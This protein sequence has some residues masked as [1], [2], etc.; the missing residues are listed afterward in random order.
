MRNY[1]TKIKYHIIFPIFILFHQSFHGGLMFRRFIIFGLF[2]ICFSFN[3]KSEFFKAEFQLGATGAGLIN[4]DEYSLH[5]FFAGYDSD[6]DGELNTDLGEEPASWYFFKLN[7]PN[8]FETEHILDFD[9]FI[10]FPFR[11]ARKGNLLYVPLEN[12]I[13]IC[14]LESKTILD[15]NFLEISAS[16]LS[17]FDNFLFISVRY[18]Y[19]YDYMIDDNFV[20][21]Y[22][23]QTK[24][25]LDTLEAYDFVQQTL[26]VMWGNNFYLFVLNE[27][28]FG[29]DDSKLQIFK[30]E[31]MRLNEIQ[32]IDIGSGG[33]YLAQ[34]EN[35]IAIVSSGSNKIHFFDLNTF[36]IYKSFDIPGEPWNGP[37]EI[38]FTGNDNI[39]KEAF[40]EFIVSTYDNKI[41]SHKNQEITLLDEFDYKI[42]S[43]AFLGPNLCA[44]SSFDADYNSAKSLYILFNPF[45]SI[46][47]NSSFDLKIY[48]NP[49]SGILQISNDENNIIKVIELYDSKGLFIEKIQNDINAKNI[50]INLNKFQLS[51][52]L[53]ILKIIS[54]NQIVNQPFILIK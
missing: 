37:R 4:T 20:I 30:Y 25:F 11:P 53:Y 34:Y 41:Y 22:E 15:N 16:A 21:V 12:K 48:P 28:N 2:L 18:D 8:N 32:V 24:R 47:K 31:N 51:N 50:L 44:L 42:E 45:T 3:L 27:G 7:P 14:D 9:G 10:Q 39:R 6:F 1:E 52:G 26:P 23:L 38:I 13:I 36:G 35:I 5:I 43:L 29:S 17:I 33:N 19:D 40:G 46:Q 49:T 54:D